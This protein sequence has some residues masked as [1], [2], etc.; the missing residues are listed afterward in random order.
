MAIFS[1]LQQDVNPMDAIVP[2]GQT[3][4]PVA[5]G[6][7]SLTR[8]FLSGGGSE[9]APTESEAFGQR[10][11]EFG[12]IINNPEWNPAEASMGELRAFGSR[13]PEYSTKAFEA[14][15]AG[16]NESV[17][18]Y[19]NSLT[20]EEQV[21]LEIEK[22]WQTSAEGIYANAKAR[23][24]TNPEE[25][26]AY[27]A[28]QRAM[29]VTMQ[30]ENARIKREVDTQGAYTTLAQNAWNNNSTSART[31]A[32]IF[33]NGL[34]EL[35]KA[36]AADPTASFNLNELG[37]S[38]ILPELQLSPVVN[39]S[40]IESVA[41]MA[42][43]ALLEKARRDVSTKTGMPS[44]AL[45]LPP[46]DWE[47]SVFAT[48]DTTLDWIKKEVDPATISSRMQDKAF[49]EMSQAGVPVQYLG[50]IAK[51]SGANPALSAQLMAG[52][53]GP[54]GKFNEELLAGRLEEANRALK[55]SSKRDLIDARFAFT[56]LVAVM[57][58]QSTLARTYEEVTQD[59]K[60]T[61]IGTAILGAITSHQEIERTDGPTR[62]NRS[63]WRQNF[64]IPAEAINRRSQLDPEFTQKTSEFLSSD[65]M[66][67]LGDLRDAAAPNGVNISIS[68]NG[69]V[70]ISA[71][72]QAASLAGATLGPRRGPLT[73]Q[74]KL[75]AFK[76]ERKALID[77]INYKLTVLGRLGGLGESTLGIIRGEVPGAV[78]PNQ[79]ETVTINDFKLPKEIA[80]DKEFIGAVDNLASSL[81]LPSSDILRVIEFETAGSWSPAVKNPNS[82]ATGLIQ[83]LES[84]A[85]GLGTSTAELAGMTRSQQMEFVGRYLEPF[86]GRIKNFGDLYMAIHF[87]KAV[88]QSETYVM[89]KQGSPEY[90]ANS[91]LDSNGDGT[92]TRG[93]TIAS[94]ISRTGGGAM[95]TPSTAQ[96]E[97]FTTSVIE[98]GGQ[99]ALPTETQLAPSAA[100]M[101]GGAAAPAET[102]VQP[103]DGGAAPEAALPETIPA[104]AQDQAGGQQQQAQ[105]PVDAEVR[106]FIEEIAANPDKTFASEADFQAAQQNGELEPGDSVVVDGVAYMIRKDGTA[107]RIGNI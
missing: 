80:D 11:R 3:G 42:R 26:A 51:L 35:T 45:G 75:N 98:Q 66:L 76:Q 104:P 19:E 107:R 73:P 22:A 27:V 63:A 81:N 21:S 97:A 48:F 41:N 103:V 95:T 4:A 65:I 71:T 13:N 14:A 52:L 17:R 60:D 87:P 2:E 83:F 8:V 79:T 99:A 77:D 38:Q 36:I 85:K 16:L 93:E 78:S 84:T 32:N 88:G 15:K 56:E 92:V 34:T 68:D 30:A 67:D 23:E 64:E 24:Y 69:Q 40:N 39:Q 31:E 12:E 25:G 59:Q 102:T 49:L 54:A 1:P 57:S 50:A 29:F 100:G 9:R 43:A 72:A 28:E 5:E 58:G 106:A 101:G 18:A 61:E 44:D 33:A 47:K 53:T 74:D 96:A 86:R 37:I 70:V 89:Y 46:A 94:V 20:L 7:A 55:E 62:W 10:V 91:N 6:I 105:Q 82:T 90:E